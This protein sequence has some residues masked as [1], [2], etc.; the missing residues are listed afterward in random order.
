MMSITVGSKREI[1][2]ISPAPSDEDESISYD[3][4]KRHRVVVSLAEVKI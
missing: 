4:L 2:D 1:S 3:S